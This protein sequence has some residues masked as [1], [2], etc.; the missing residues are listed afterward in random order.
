M[1]V[2][3]LIGISTIVDFLGLEE[4]LHS[5]RNVRYVCHEQVTLLIGQLIEVV[6]MLVICNKATTMIGLL[7]EEES[8]RNTQMC[9]FNHQV[10][11]GLIIGTIETIFRIRM[12]DIN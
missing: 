1:Q 9:D 4:L 7:F 3:E 2:A 12:H 5:A 11:K 10:V 6:H 8:T